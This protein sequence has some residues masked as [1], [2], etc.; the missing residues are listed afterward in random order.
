M[1]I[2]ALKR[3]HFASKNVSSGKIFTLNS[4]RGS[5]R[6]SVLTTQYVL[7]QRK[8]WSKRF[9]HESE[10]QSELKNKSH[11]L[12][13]IYNNWVQP[14]STN[15]SLGASDNHQSTYI[16]NK[17][18]RNTDYTCE[19]GHLPIK[20]PKQCTKNCPTNFVKNLNNTDDFYVKY[21]MKRKINT[22]LC[23]NKG[24]N[25]PFPYGV[26]GAKLTYLNKRPKVVLQAYQAV[27]YYS[28]DL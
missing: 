27:D 4:S 20:A 23:S 13:K 26:S 2:V 8:S 14:T 25:K 6:S 16:V 22:I 19:Y 17:T 15:A 1:S 24:F 10:I 28:N 9:P 11:N 7:S 12:Q 21:K 18:I 5:P 3:K